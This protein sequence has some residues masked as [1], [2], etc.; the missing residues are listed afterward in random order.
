MLASRTPSGRLFRRHKL[1]E[2]SGNDRGRMT[3]ALAYL[4]A[5]GRI[6]H[7][8]VPSLAK[9]YGHLD[10][11]YVPITDM[12]PLCSALVWRRSATHPK[13]REFVQIARATASGSLGDSVTRR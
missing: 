7:P 3:S 5:T 11:V 13:L 4:I 10:I 1:D 8:T 6:V 9:L 12:P 2:H